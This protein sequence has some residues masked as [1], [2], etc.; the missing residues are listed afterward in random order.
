[1][2]LCQF[3]SP[4]TFA[5]VHGVDYRHHPSLDSLKASAQPGCALCQLFYDCLLDRIRELDKIAGSH[6]S[7]EEYDSTI[8]VEAYP[9]EMERLLGGKE[10]LTIRSGAK[11]RLL[12]GNV[13]IL[14]SSSK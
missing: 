12:S 8:W 5:S 7:Q 1:M 11:D 9:S 2:P 6:G 10:R 3:C 14:A 4:F 13:A